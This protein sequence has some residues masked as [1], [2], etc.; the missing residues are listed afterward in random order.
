M[1]DFQCERCH[2]TGRYMARS[3]M[4]TA[5]RCTY[6]GTTYSVCQGREP[7]I[8]TP[9]FDPAGG[10][11]SPW[12]AAKYRP[13]VAGEYECEFRN[14]LRLVLEWN[15]QC[16]VHRGRVVDMV[17]HYKWRGKWA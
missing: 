9:E 15:G 17:D 3:D 16:W 13:Y 10:R 11:L 5:H 14:G 4:N 2:R 6:C 7:S 12:I 8:I 1:S